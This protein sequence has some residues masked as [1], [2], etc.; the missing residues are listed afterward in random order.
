MSTVGQNDRWERLEE[1]FAEAVELPPDLQ[2]SFVDRETASDPGL[3]KQLRALLEHDS[4]AASRI[5]SVVG[6]AS[7]AAAAPVDWYGRRFGPYRI[8]REIGRGGFGIVFEA[9]RDDDE[10]RKT[11]ALKIAPWWRDL[12]TLH[13]RFRYERQILAGLEHPYIARF[14]DGGTQD[15]IP[16][17][18]MEYVEGV[19]ITEYVR[20]RP[21]TLRQT[22]ELFRQVCT[23][24]HYAHQSLIVHRDLKP[25]NILVTGEGVPKLLDFG[26][27]KLLS[28]LED[29]ARTTTGSMSWTP[30]YASPEQVRALPIT[31]RTDV[32]SLGL[33]FFELLTG[34][35]AQVADTSSP[36]AIDRSIC[37]TPVPL[38]SNKAP[39]LARQLRGDLNNIIAKAT[40]KDPE[41][42]YPSVVELSDDL[43][44]YLAGRPVRARTDGTAYRV[45][46]FLKRNA[47][48]VSA[49]VVVA[50][51][52]VI[53]TAVAL[54]QAQR[55]DRRF[56][57]VRKLANTFL[58]SFHDQIQNLAGSTRARE[59]VVKTALEY[60]D[61]LS[62]EAGGDV[63]LQ[64]EL[65]NAYLRVARVQGDGR[66]AN[67]G[68]IDASLE[69]LHK[70]MNIG[71]DIL[72]RRPNDA[73]ALRLMTA[74]HGQLGDTWALFKGNVAE[75]TIQHNRAVAYAEQLSRS[76][77]ATNADRADL[78]NALLK[79]GDALID[80]AP[81]E[82]LAA[83]QRAMEPASR[84][85][86]A[87]PGPSSTWLV[88]QVYQRLGRV[89]HELGDPE[90]AI[91]YL[92]ESARR[93][94]R[95]IEADPNNARYRRELAVLYSFLGNYSG[96][97]SYFNLGKP[98]AA[99]DYYRQ[100][101]ALDAQLAS[102]DP[103]DAR[104]RLDRINNALKIAA[105][106]I[107]GGVEERVRQAR[108]ALAAIDP[109][110][111]QAPSNFR[112]RSHRQNGLSVL[113][114]A[115]LDAG[116]AR[117]AV[118]VLGESLDEADRLLRAS[119]R[120]LGAREAY[121]T[122]LDELGQAFLAAKD[123]DKAAANLNR[124]RELLEQTHAEMPYDLYFLRDLALTQEHLGWLADARARRDGARQWYQTAL[125]SWDAWRKLTRDNAYVANQVARLNERLKNN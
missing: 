18:A 106:P 45:S 37:E 28:P 69:S 88:A 60:L 119:P 89:S 80:D 94:K 93:Q 124:A 110:V 71:E 117:E 43:E 113:G 46:K 22:I 8:V 102:A 14:L 19:P 85:E 50:A 49:A 62:A 9:V 84:V 92:E 104:G 57:Q 33:I 17:F 2:S 108:F 48:P 58:F 4:G 5:N 66:V 78:A 99:L 90:A 79:Q 105:I 77:G 64:E 39:A 82:A 111:S 68:Q 63:A 40:Q 115:L 47:I 42:R 107:P 96:N 16:Y 112:Y 74:V 116:K 67:L 26:I 35:R 27:A 20:S 87:A 98:A 56:Q 65:G 36:L 38:A 13:D 41:R 76:P 95:L 114:G 59:F 54:V 7:R 121:D 3:R 125:R 72:R 34:Q 53:G 23:A 10:Y 52:M 86:A 100:A 15:G 24:V 101:Y 32:Y 70:A 6:H 31:T 12:Q 61:S 30:D 123:W 44:N 83:F 120:D 51:S 11:V 21:L 109:M 81:K 97:S 29:L 1:L 118:R 103:N 73:G 91:R 25:G 55:A 122:G 75:G